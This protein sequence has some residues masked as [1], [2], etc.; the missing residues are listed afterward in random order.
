MHR[1]PPK[2]HPRPDRG[3]LASLVYFFFPSQQRNLRGGAGA[4]NSSG[5]VAEGP[6]SLRSHARGRVSPRSHG[7]VSHGHSAAPGARE[8]PGSP[9]SPQEHPHPGS[10]LSPQEH[11]RPGS[12]SSPQE[13]PHSGTLPIPQEHPHPGSP[14]SLQK[15]RLLPSLPQALPSS[16]AGTDTPTFGDGRQTSPHRL[17]LPLGRGRHWAR[18][19]PGETRR[20]REGEEGTHHTPPAQ[21]EPNAAQPRRQLTAR[22]GGSGG[23]SSGRRAPRRPLH[24]QRPLRLPSGAATATGSSARRERGTEEGRRGSRS[25]AGKVGGAAAGRVARPRCARTGPGAAAAPAA[26]PSRD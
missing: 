20:R 23:V 19:A 12:P 9:P 22:S 24:G 21:P 16:P 4:G 26:P 15:Q 1:H 10:A 5:G 17:L 14:P 25:P 3:V 18:P 8:P 7:A 6:V 2:T 13:H 11:P